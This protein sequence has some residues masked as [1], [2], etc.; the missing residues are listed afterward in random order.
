MCWQA[1]AKARIPPGFDMNVSI[2]TSG[3]WP[4][5]PIQDAVL[6]EELSQSQVRSTA[7]DPLILLHPIHFTYGKSVREYCDQAP[8]TLSVAR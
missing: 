6:P 3:Y 7:S 8:A 1:T 5:Y 4:T 2:L